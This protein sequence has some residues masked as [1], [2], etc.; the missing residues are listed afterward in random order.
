MARDDASFEPIRRNPS[1]ELNV[2]TN[3]KPWTDDYSNIL[4]AILFRMRPVVP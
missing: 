2:E 3:S 1:W 4:Q